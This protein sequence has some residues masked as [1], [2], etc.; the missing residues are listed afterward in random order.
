MLQRRGGGVVRGRLEEPFTYVHRSP[1]SRAS[2]LAIKFECRPACV[3]C[4]LANR[5]DFFVAKSTSGPS[6]KTPAKSV[7]G[8]LEFLLGGAQ[9]RRSV[10]PL[11]GISQQVRTL[12]FSY[13][14]HRPHRSRAQHALDCRSDRCI[15]RQGVQQSTWPQPGVPACLGRGRNPVACVERPKPT[16]ESIEACGCFGMVPRLAWI[17]RAKYLL[18]A[19]LLACAGRPLFSRRH[20]CCA[21]SFSISL[22]KKVGPE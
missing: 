19:E 14:E 3:R 15:P 4:H 22:L 20:R 5:V 12:T 10:T 2:K 18:F 6:Y 11:K 9:A 1:T 13:R 21:A 17:P 16:R 8:Q 7:F